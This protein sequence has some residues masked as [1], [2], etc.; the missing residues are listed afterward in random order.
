MET[1]FRGAQSDTAPQ[2]IET[3]PIQED[4][5]VPLE[6]LTGKETSGAL[7]DV[8]LSLEVWENENKRKYGID[9]FDI[10]ETS[11]EF[12]IKAQFG[13]VDKFVKSEIE[14]R[15]LKSSKENYAKILSEIENE[16]GT[17]DMERFKRLQRIFNYIQV[18]K[19]YRDIK[20]KRESFKITT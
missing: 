13:F 8:D 16:I 11:N 15:G 3:A 1:T 14:S 2:P 5:G 12:P 9:Y 7:D 20:E 19:K 10:R 4:K 17:K 6:E 18:M